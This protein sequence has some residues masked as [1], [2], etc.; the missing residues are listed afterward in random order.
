MRSNSSDRSI[1][2]FPEVVVA[3]TIGDGCVAQRQRGRREDRG[4]RAGIAVAGENVEDDVGGV[5]AL[6][7]CLGAGGLDRWQPVGEHRGEDVDH[8]AI[9]VVMQS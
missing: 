6:G 2:W 7:G 4:G 9:A 5:N 8:L 1:R 3:G